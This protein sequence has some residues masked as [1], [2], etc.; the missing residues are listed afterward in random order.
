M[1]AY[2]KLPWAILDSGTKSSHLEVELN[3]ALALKIKNSD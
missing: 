3:R 1:A 2:E